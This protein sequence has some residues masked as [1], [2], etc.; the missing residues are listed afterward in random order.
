MNV[1]VGTCVNL[2]PFNRAMPA[3]FN[4]NRAH[5]FFAE[6]KEPTLLEFTK[7]PAANGNINLAEQIGTDYKYFGIVILEDKMG[8]LTDA[9]EKRH[10]LIAKDINTDIFTQWLRGRGRKPVSW[11]TLVKVLQEIGLQTLAEDVRK[12]KC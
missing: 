5:L 1:E 8:D 9:A 2:D 6:N 4:A 11:D 12:I 7:F 10:H 3:P